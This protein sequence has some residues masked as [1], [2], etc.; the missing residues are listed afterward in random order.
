[1]KLKHHRKRKE[2]FFSKKNDFFYHSGQRI[3]DQAQEKLD[4]SEKRRDD[5]L[6]KMEKTMKKMIDV[7]SGIEHLADKLHHLKGVC[8][9]EIG[10]LFEIE[11]ISRPKVKYL[12]RLYHHNQMIMFLIYLVQQKK[13]LLNLLKNLKLKI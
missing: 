11:F 12:Q 3:L 7:K 2:P 10:F 1:V 4:E 13:N 6:I 8:F 9:E 5:N